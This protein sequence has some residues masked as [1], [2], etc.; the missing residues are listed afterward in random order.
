MRAAATPDTAHLAPPGRGALRHEKKLLLG[1]DFKDSAPCMEPSE[2]ADISPDT[3]FFLP[4][5][6]LN[7]IQPGQDHFHE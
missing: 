5:L 4:S 1:V 7:F 3:G 2:P 6:S